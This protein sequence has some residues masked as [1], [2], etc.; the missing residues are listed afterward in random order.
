M[1]IWLIALASGAPLPRR[2]V[3]I[4]NRRTVV[5]QATEDAARILRI[6]EQPSRAVDHERTACRIRDALAQLS[7]DSASIPLAISA[8]RG[9]LADNSAWKKSPAR[10]AIIIGTIDMIGSKLLFAGYGDGRY[11][12]AHHAGLIGQDTLIVHDEA[13]LTPAFDALLGSVE[14]EQRRTNEA[15]PIRVMRLSATTR[16]GAKGGHDSPF[17]IA[18]EDRL[19]GVISQRLNARKSLRIVEAEKGKANPKI[20]EEALGLGA[21]PGRV[22]VY[23]RAPEVAMDIAATIAERLGKGSDSRVALLTGTIRGYERDAMV[24]GPILAAFRSS[25]N[26]PPL[27]ESMFLVSTSAGEVGADWDAD[28]LVCDLSTLDGMAQRFGRVNRLG[29]DGRAAEV[30]VVVERA[31]AEGKG[32]AS[33]LDAAIAKTAEVLDALSKDGGDVSPGALGRIMDQLPDHER[34][35]AFSPEPTILPATDILF[36]N[37]SLTSIAGD[38]PGRPAVEPYL[39]GVADWDP[40]QTHVAWRADI[41]VL[42]RAGGEHVP[43]SITDLE[44]VFE[45]FP[46]RSVEQLRD[47][48]DRVLTEL[49]EIAARHSAQRVVILKNGQARWALID[50]LIDG[51]DPKRLSSSPLAFATIVLPT[52]L[53][54][55]TRSGTLQGDIPAP[56]DPDD[57]HAHRR[58]DVAEAPPGGTQERQRVLV[59]PDEPQGSPLLGGAAIDA[60]GRLSVTLPGAG[61]EDDP[62]QA[63]QYRVARGEEREPGERIPLD[64]HN[65]S[66]GAAAERIARALGLPDA[67]VRAAALAG[68]WHD[69][70]KGR[71]VWQ[72]YANNSGNG[73][74]IAKSDRYAHWKL[75]GGYRHEFGSLIDADTALPADQPER[76]LILH[77]IAAHHGWARPH[78]ETRHFDRSKPSAS[79]DATAVAALQRFARLQQRIGRWHLAS[80]ESILRSADAE[81]SESAAPADNGAERPTTPGGAA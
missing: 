2:L 9:E 23:V 77:L 65:K 46:L 5:D 8:L 7:G 1:A 76:D 62:P 48:T 10:P 70:G 64:A 18:H 53:G 71:E 32:R 79:C 69:A 25:P 35:V 40:P 47:R 12:R 59:G 16:A 38:M 19:D 81:A 4:V 61:D 20:T 39:H 28:H 36:D 43:C 29:G 55:L 27:A 6:L 11:G 37:W 51:T 15:R 80:L 31:S 66:V 57:P 49:K 50:E 34:R 78:F 41:G 73:Q 33:P 26:R 13:H 56:S 74:P 54:G 67:L 42:A 17:G 45:A 52:E 14:R 3:Y 60:V 63:I 24:N 22:L 44:E 58:L 21:S 68:Q 75:L 72:R 30:V